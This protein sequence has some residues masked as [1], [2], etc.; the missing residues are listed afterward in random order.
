MTRKLVFVGLVWLTVWPLVT[1]LLLVIEALG[2]MMP[3]AVT[4]FLLTAAMV[5]AIT[6]VI[7]PVAARGA[8]WIHR[9]R[10]SR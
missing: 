7:S 2:V 5:P 10:Q 1:L 8:D 3:I 9:P 6:F 4:P